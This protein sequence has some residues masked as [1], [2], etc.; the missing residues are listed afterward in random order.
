MEEVDGDIC[1][2]SFPDWLQN[3]SMSQLSTEIPDC[4]HNITFSDG[5]FLPVNPLTHS[6]T[7]PPSVREDKKAEKAVENTDVV[8]SMAVS[9]QGDLGAVGQHDYSEHDSC[10]DMDNETLVGT[11]QVTDPQSQLQHVH[12]VAIPVAASSSS[13]TITTLHPTMNSNTIILN[14]ST[15]D[16]YS[17]AGAACI[18][19]ASAQELQALSSVQQE[20]R[21]VYPKPVY[22]YNCLIGLALKN[23]AAGTLPVHEIYTFISENFPYFKTAPDGW[24]NSVRHN[25]SQNKFFMKVHN[26]NTASSKKGCLWG[27]NPAKRKKNDDDIIKCR[28]KDPANVH[29]SMAYPE[30][31]EAIE[32]G[33]AGLP[34]QTDHDFDV[35]CEE[36]REPSPPIRLKPE[37]TSTPNRRGDP[38]DGASE[39]GDMTSEA[40]SSPWDGD[41]EDEQ[42]AL[43]W[44]ITDADIDN[45]D[46]DLLMSSPIHSQ[47]PPRLNPLSHSVNNR[48]PSPV[49]HR[50]GDEVSP[51]R[52]FVQCTPSV[53]RSNLLDFEA[54]TPHTLP[55][56]NG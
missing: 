30:N 29:S 32:S 17:V 47:D 55:A 40:E 27:M 46:I 50:H 51:A 12:I 1:M 33:R 22:S 42:L 26:P 49:F 7:S 23:S 6:P 37:F 2:D 38:E 19:L 11:E 4:E 5:H 36:E 13:G 25:L 20:E 35:E 45:L 48:T 43:Q 10:S 52:L 8:D 15:G 14:T 3:S 56:L 24:K 54:T 34:F 44:G 53:V 31:L 41:D 21:K 18:N 39:Q 28:K 9:V 16:T